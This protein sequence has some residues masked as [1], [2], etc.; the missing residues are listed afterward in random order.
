VSR[1]KIVLT[2]EAQDDIECARAWYAAEGR[3]SSAS[4]FWLRTKEAIH[5]LQDSPLSHRVDEDG[6]RQL[7]LRSFPYSICYTVSERTVTVHAVAHQA[8]QPGYW[9]AGRLPRAKP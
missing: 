3:P 2:L 8:R 9:R 4:D 1:F 7:G 6:V 5:R